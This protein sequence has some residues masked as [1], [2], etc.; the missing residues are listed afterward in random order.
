MSFQINVYPDGDQI[1]AI[2][3]E[4]PNES[5]IGFGANAIEALKNLI[6]DMEDQGPVGW[7][8]WEPST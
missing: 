7:W 3:G 1:C 5:A 6:V 8:E 2:I 4:M